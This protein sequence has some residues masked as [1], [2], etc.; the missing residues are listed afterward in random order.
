[1]ARAIPPDAIK[2]S[3]NFRLSRTTHLRLWRKLNL[4]LINAEVLPF[5]MAPIKA[6]DSYKRCGNRNRKAIPPAISTQ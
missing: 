2:L 6:K 5:L 4:A 1:L 3:R